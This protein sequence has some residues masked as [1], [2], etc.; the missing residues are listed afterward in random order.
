MRWFAKLFGHGPDKETARRA[1]CAPA[2]LECAVASAREMLATLIDA[3]GEDSPL[4]RQQ[5]SY[6]DTLLH[7]LAA[8]R[9]A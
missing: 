1:R 2:D 7:E 5:Q 4:V 8:G 3:Y 6:I 9:A